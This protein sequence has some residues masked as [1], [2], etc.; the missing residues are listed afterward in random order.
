MATTEGIIRDIAASKECCVCG[1]LV[2]DDFEPKWF[3][4]NR[5]AHETCW[6]TLVLKHKG[7]MASVYVEGK[8]GP[9]NEEGNTNV[10]SVRQ[11]SQVA[12]SVSR[13]H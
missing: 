6:G 12:S 10:R 5:A 4:A 7:D 2:G 11:A 13:N 3:G 9:I 1:E 8:Y